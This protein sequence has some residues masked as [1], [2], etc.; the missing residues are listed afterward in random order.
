MIP[1]NLNNNHWVLIVVDLK[2]KN[3]ACFDSFSIYGDKISSTIMSNIT[4]FFEDLHNIKSNY[5]TNLNLIADFTTDK[6]DEDTTNTNKVILL[7]IQEKSVCSS[8]SNIIDENLSEKAEKNI[9]N[10]K[11]YFPDCPKQNN[12]SDCG[13]FVCKFMDNITREQNF[14]FCQDDME[15]LRVLLGIELIKGN[16]LTI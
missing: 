10:W 2:N 15:F 9:T 7:F 6:I 1:V 12:F 4:K 14:D 16:V 5:N 11:F 8:N 3:I 13:M